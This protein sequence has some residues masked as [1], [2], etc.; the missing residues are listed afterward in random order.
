MDSP[1]LVRKIRAHQFVAQINHTSDDTNLPNHVRERAAV[2]RQELHAFPLL[3]RLVPDLENPWKPSDIRA[4]R[5]D[6][7]EKAFEGRKR[8]PPKAGRGKE[9]LPWGLRLLPPWS[10][11]LVARY[12]LVTFPIIEKRV[13]VAGKKKYLAAAKTPA[14]V[15]ALRSLRMMHVEW[16][17]QQND[18]DEV[19]YAL[20]I[21]RGRGSRGRYDD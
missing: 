3:G 8:R 20:E 12:F 13:T 19:R 7:W 17:G 9:K 6:E 16:S 2:A 14:E 4:A 11:A 1:D 21:L 15:K 10:R 5:E 18:L